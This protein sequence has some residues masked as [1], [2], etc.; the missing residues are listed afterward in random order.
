MITLFVSS[1]D[2]YTVELRQLL[3]SK[4]IS[5]L[6]KVIHKMYPSMMN[7]KV[8][9]AEELHSLLTEETV[10]H[11]EITV[12]VQRLIDI[13]ITIKPLMEKDLEQLSND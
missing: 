9:G 5:E 7:M 3:Q 11:E 2:E 1:L 10:W 12:A 13:F 6:K 4:D 8:Q